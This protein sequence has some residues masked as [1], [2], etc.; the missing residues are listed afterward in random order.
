MTSW[1][2]KAPGIGEIGLLVA[3]LIL[4]AVLRMA[5]PG[6]IEFKRD[7]A[8]LFARALDVAD[9]SHFHLRGISSS[10]G[11]P[12]SP[13]SV[14]LYALPLLLW[15]DIYAAS[16][17]TG[18]VN[19]GAILG[20]WWLVRRYWGGTAAL[21][22]TIMFAVS[23]WA[24]FHSQK[25]WA[26]NL[27]APLIVGW[28]IAA[29][30]AIV[31]RRRGFILLHLLCLAIAV[32][33][34]FAAVALIPATL[35]L[36]V[37]F[38]RRVDWRLLL[39]ACLIA[40]LTVVPFFIY[41]FSHL[42]S[43]LNL[44]ELISRSPERSFTL[45]AWRF[46]WLLT[47][48]REIHA[49]AGPEAFE[50]FLTGV[51]DLTMIH[52]FWTALV[53]GGVVWLTRKVRHSWDKDDPPAE[54]GFIILV[55]LLIPPLIFTIPLMPVELHYLLPV[56]P[57]QYIVAGIAFAHLARRL[58]NW[59]PAAWTVFGFSAVTLVWV[60]LSLFGFI[61]KQATPGGYGTPVTYYRQ[62]VD[63]ARLRQSQEN[64]Q[65]IIIGGSSENPK[66]DSFA[67]VFDVLLRDSP[68]RFVDINQSALFPANEAIVILSPEA[69]TEG[70]IAYR[71]AASHLTPIQ[72]RQGEGELQ[73][74]T[75]S[76]DSAPVPEN[77]LE[78][79]HLF[80]NWVTLYGYDD[81]VA[82]A[83]EPAIW[84][85]YWQTGDNPD[86]AQYH[87]FNH[88]LDEEE[89]RLAQAD[90]PIFS[91]GQWQSGDRVIG[92]YTFPWAEGMEIPVSVRTGIYNYPSLESVPLLD[93]AGNPAGDSV[94]LTLR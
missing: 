25:I 40:L 7:E 93:I 76:A 9:G 8:L 59:R 24:I 89:T 75:L 81:L 48:G 10:V 71:Q 49:L 80:A 13:L 61:S 67:A 39:L 46:L 79:S 44:G 78:A 12:N 55:W 90:G 17:F 4:A 47:T 86:Q 20:G 60:W 56:Y 18:L 41:L 38:R 57:A 19:V 32:Q 77:M 50:E 16:L 63:L 15:K 82:P 43:D 68:H 52:A 54:A 11:F 26:Q 5:W 87:F 66:Q 33:V 36:L 58:G 65:E 85:I 45:E 53:I 35:L 88:L 14:W 30:L 28:A 94:I 51:P 3:V 64:G 92:F 34:H 1:K 62:A 6:L 84:R 74:L 72:L 23:P 2:R 37:V 73:I 21:T 31:E 69:N 83:G 22:A 42:G 91:P 29:M 70:A 27:L